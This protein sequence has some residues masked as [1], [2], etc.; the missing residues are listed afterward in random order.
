MA[1]TTEMNTKTQNLA[2]I[3]KKFKRD[4]ISDISLIDLYLTLRTSI[5]SAFQSLM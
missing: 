3:C 1:I 2:S 5:V 4:Q